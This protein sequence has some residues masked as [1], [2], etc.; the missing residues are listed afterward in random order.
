MGS[1]ATIGV[2]SDFT[3]SILALTSITLNT[4]AS[5][6]YGR[7]LARNGAVTLDS[8]VID[9]RDP[10]AGYCPPGGRG[11]P[12]VLTPVPEAS[13]YGLIGSVVLLLA[14]WRRRVA[15]RRNNALA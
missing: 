5:I 15:G 14:V 8:N 12:P 7:A 4:G 3:G 1:S 10:D 2:N 9:A 13:T 11:T 6:D